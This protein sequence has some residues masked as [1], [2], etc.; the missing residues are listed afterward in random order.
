M[1]HRAKVFV[2]CGQRG[3]GEIESSEAIASLLGDKG[4]EPY[5]AKK[6]HT[7][8][9]INGDII[10]ALKSSDYYLFVNFR[11]EQ[12]VP[13]VG[14]PPFYRGSV[15]TNQE[16]AIAYAMEFGKENLLML[17][18]KG[19]E[20]EGLLGYFGVNTPEFSDA[21][22]LL[23]VLE[24]SLDNA[25]WCP[26]FSRQL[27][28]SGVINPS[29]VIEYRVG[30]WHYHSRI[31]RVRIN[32]NRHDRAAL[33]ATLRFRSKTTSQPPVS[34]QVTHVERADLKVSGRGVYATA[35]WPQSFVDFDLL[36]VDRD[37]PNVFL[38]SNTDIAPIQ[39]L[40][41]GP[42]NFRLEY[43]LFAENFPKLRFEVDLR[44][45]ENPSEATVD[46]V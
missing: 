39:P 12:V 41:A 16:L 34:V 11:R 27:V 30:G 19:V 23:S 31:F 36:G 45:P 20:R 24:S 40:L 26:E 37:S 38:H 18:E 5:V 42:G 4:F 6:V 25:K 15:F 3:D 32:N 21:S 35:I 44:L 14:S 7:L 28:P 10:D 46:L 17:N 1:G 9:D 2:S 43:E 22:N 13:D 8:M 33:N 29:Q